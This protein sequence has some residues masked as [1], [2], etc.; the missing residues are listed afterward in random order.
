M[1]F[2]LL[3]LLVTDSQGLTVAAEQSVLQSFS[4]A[5][6]FFAIRDQNLTHF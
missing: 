2:F 5:C 4:W 1:M 6:Y 3:V